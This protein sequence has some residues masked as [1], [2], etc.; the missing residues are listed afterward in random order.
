MD[1]RGV[2]TDSE[3]SLE[4]IPDLTCRKIRIRI[5]SRMKEEEDLIKS[6]SN[7][8][9]KICIFWI[10]RKFPL[11]YQSYVWS[12]FEVRIYKKISKYMIINVKMCLNMIFS[13]EYSVKSK[14]SH[15]AHL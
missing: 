5:W 14:S 10:D 6:A 15:Q 3:P 7:L 4:S 12:V 11:V 9:D 8:I 2:D 13:N 1:P